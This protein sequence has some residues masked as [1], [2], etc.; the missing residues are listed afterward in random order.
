MIELTTGIAFLVS[1]LYSG[2][3]IPTALADMVSSTTPVIQQST[4]ARFMDSKV[5]EAYVRSEFADEPLLVEIARCESTFRQYD[6]TGNT[7]RGKVNKGDIGVMQ[8]NEYYHAEDATKLGIN[9]YTVDGNMA[10]GKY[11]YKKYGSQP[12][13]SSAPCWSSGTQL[14]L[15]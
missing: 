12:W 9:I 6:K 4:E 7:L 10:F 13:I 3:Q 14:A 15:K 2:S 8:I 5:L 11:L 1:S